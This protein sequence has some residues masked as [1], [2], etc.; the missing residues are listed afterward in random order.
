MRVQ[1]LR[2]LAPIPGR[3]AVGIEI[4]NIKP[5]IIYFKDI[6]SDPGF[7]EDP[8]SLTLALGKTCS[9]KPFFTNLESMPHLLIAG[10]TGT[11]KS[12]CINALIASLVYKFTP[13][14][15]RLIMID[16]KVLELYYL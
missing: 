3:A 9:D 6:I 8:D 1:S 10:A 4:P 15:L 13:D 12:V 14:K 2:I 11:G 7:L 16:P 5:D